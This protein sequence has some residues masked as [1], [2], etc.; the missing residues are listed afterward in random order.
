VLAK[1]SRL[2]H[3]AL[4]LLDNTL[5]ESHRRLEIAGRERCRYDRIH[6]ME[7]DAVDSA[8]FA[9][10]EN[11]FVMFALANVVSQSRMSEPGRDNRHDLSGARGKVPQ[12]ESR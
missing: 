4:R 10:I 2:V 12:E 3:Q 11:R 1:H 8:V 6:L 5:R 7:V 9:W